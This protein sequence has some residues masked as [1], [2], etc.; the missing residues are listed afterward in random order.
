WGLDWAFGDVATQDGGLFV[1]PFWVRPLHGVLMRMCLADAD[2]TNEYKDALTQ[3]A[4]RWDDLELEALMDEW[5]AQI[6]DA[7]AE[8]TRRKTTDEYVEQRREIRRQFIRGRAESLRA[9][10]AAH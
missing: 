10:I 4:D 2:C 6:S 5:I 7:F 3:V 8:D 9:A 1:D